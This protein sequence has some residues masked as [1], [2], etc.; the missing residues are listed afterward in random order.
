MGLT[1]EF[2][3]GDDKKIIKGVKDID[4]ELLDD[5]HCITKK[6]DFSLHISPKDLNTLSITLSTFNKLK[7]MGVRENLYLIID[8]ADYGLFW[9]DEKWVNYVSMINTDEL[10]KITDEWFRQMQKQYPNEILEVTQSAI[11]A[12]KDLHEL[13]EVAIKKRKTVFHYWC[14]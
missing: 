14:G 11:D 7:P 8:E 1:L 2:L 6:A 4:F 9:I 13:C 12:I 5:E 10:E 3:I